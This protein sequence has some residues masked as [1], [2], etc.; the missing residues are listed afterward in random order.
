MVNDNKTT[1]NDINTNRINILHNNQPEQMR[2]ENIFDSKTYPQIVGVTGQISPEFLNKYLADF[3]QVEI[4]IGNLP[5]RHHYTSMENVTKDALATAL[6]QTANK[7]SIRLFQNMSSQLQMAAIAG[8]LKLETAPTQVIHSRF[9]LL[10]NPVTKQTRVVLGS[11]DLTE[12]S[13][14]S[15]AN[16]FE[17]IMIFDDQPLY[18]QLLKHFKEDLRPVLQPYFT[19]ELLTVAEKQLKALK[20]AKGENDNV[21]I[22]SNDDTDEISQ[23]EMTNL[24]ADDVQHQIDKQ[25]LSAGV[26]LAMRNV[27]DNRTQDQDREERAIKQRDTVLMLEKESV[28]PRAARPKIKKREVIAENIKDAMNA[29]VSPQDLA[30]E[31][32]YTTFLYDRP[33]ERNIAHNKTGLYTPN[34]AGTFPI[35]FGKLATITQIRDGIHQIQD[36]IKGYQQFV[37]DFTPEYGKRYYEAIMY[38]F[39]APFLWEIRQKASLNPEDGNDI[40]NFLILGASAGSGKTTLLRIINQFTWNTDNSLIDFGT[41]YPTGTSQRKA[42]TM[43]A[44][45]AYMKQ[46]SSYPVLVDEI[47]PYFFQQPQ[48]SRR[49]IVDTMNQLVNS[50]KPYAPLIGTTNYNSGFTMRRETARRTYYLQLDK[51][52]DNEKKGVASKYIF[53]VRQNLNNTLFKDF[54]VRMANY[55]EDDSTPWRLFDHTTGQLDFLATTR[56]IFRDYYKLIDEEVPEYFSDGLRDDFG[57]NA[58]SKW[59]KLYI[60]QKKDFI[61]HEEKN[62]LLFDITRLTTFNGFEKDS[63]EE[64]RNALPVEICVDGVNGKN[65]KFVELKAPAFYN[66]IGVENPQLHPEETT[67]DE[68]PVEESLDDETPKKRK[69]GFWARLFG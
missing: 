56:K 65:G 14:D 22:L 69:K 10:G 25:H 27:T 37:V 24:I 43:Q 28:S 8:V 60:T 20:A 29:S 45:E 67:N 48:Y 47:E 62:S 4:A 59:A 32:K 36:V 55:L 31:K 50:P 13:F 18:D 12:P 46:G 15:N 58:R 44:L 41:I 17:E 42:K 33:L 3:V 51:V 26:T 49:L 35:A 38:A 68:N 34:D 57:E 9:F 1:G 5:T 6:L 39:T 61:F 23:R 11:V 40:P 19:N 30:V 52:I 7:E 21:I 66:W 16:R 54:V 53:G 63:I 64:Y 2:I